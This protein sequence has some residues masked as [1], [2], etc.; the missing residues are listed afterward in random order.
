MRE[1]SGC[2]QNIED[3]TC[4]DD[5]E[6]MEKRKNIIPKITPIWCLKCPADGMKCSMIEH[7]N[8]KDCSCIGCTPDHPLNCGKNESE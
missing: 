6:R 1:C 5:Y 8:F 3:C 4:S 7:C 2:H